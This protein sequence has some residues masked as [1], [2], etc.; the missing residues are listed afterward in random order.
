MS[1]ENEQPTM[2]IPARSV[3]SVPLGEQS[4]L[5]ESFSAIA[6]AL[7][8]SGD[9]ST[10]L[11]SI[12]EESLRLLHAISARVRMPDATGTQL[13]L[14]ALADDETSAIRLP[15]P[16]FASYLKTDSIAGRAYR[17]NE[18]YVARG[19][20]RRGVPEEEFALH[21]T[22]PLM[23]RNRTLGVLTIWRTTDEPF[24]DDDVAIVR[25]FGNAAA[26][27]IEQIR[28]LTEER[29]RT[30]RMETLTEVARIISAATDHDALYE[31]VYAQCVRLFGVEHFYIARARADGGLIPVLWYASARRERGLEGEPLPPSLGQSVVREN[32][33]I[34]TADAGAADAEHGLAAPR[35]EEWGDTSRTFHL[36][37][38]GVPIRE[39]DRATGVIATNGRVTPYT[40]EECAVL[41]AIADQVG[42][43]MRNIDLLEEQRA[44][45]RRME[46]VTEVSRA[47]SATTDL[48]TLYEAVHQEC[49]RLFSVESFYIAHVRELT[50]EMV[51]DLWYTRGTRLHDMEGVPLEGGLSPIVARTRAPLITDDYI[52]ECKRHGIPIYYPTDPNDVGDAWM[53]MPLIAGQTLLGV[54]VV[55]GK[56][57][58]YT[59][60]EQEVFTAIANQV[61]VAITNARLL[62]EKEARAARMAA[63]AEVSRAIS[64]VTDPDV[65]YDVVYRECSRL[66]PMA[67]SRICRIV[68]ETGEIIA[69][70]YF[71]N[72]ERARELEGQ[73]LRGGLSP[74]I[75]DTGEPLLT[76]DYP[77]E[78]VRRGMAHPDAPLPPEHSSWLGVPVIQGDEVYGIISLNTTDRPLTTEDR[79]MLLSVANQVGIA[80]ANARLIARE[81]ER[82]TRMATLTEIARAISATTDRETLYDAVYAQCARLFHVE[83]LRITRV[84]PETGE[85][86]PE[87]WY[88]DGVRRLDRESIPLRYGLSFIV[89]ETRQPFTTGD[90]Y[91]ERIARGIPVSKPLN[92]GSSFEAKG[93][94][95]VPMLAGDTLLGVI[96]IYGKASAYTADEEEAFVAIVNQVSVALQ[97]VEL[98]ERERSRIERLAVLN[99][100]SR[101]MSAMLDMDELLHVIQSETP[102]LFLSQSL[103]AAYWDDDRIWFHEE[104]RNEGIKTRPFAEIME[105]R[106]LTQHVA[107]N[108]ETLVVR[109]YESDMNRRGRT[110]R[111]FSYV[112]WPTAWVG[113]PLL[114][115]GRT[116]GLIAAF[117]KPKD[118]TEAGVGILE[119]IARQAAI[120][121]ENARL[122]ERERTRAERLAILN[123][124]SHTISAVLD[125]EPLLQAIARESTR[126]LDLRFPLIGYR[127]DNA[128]WITATGPT[129]IIGHYD[130]ES[131]IGPLASIVMRT[132]AP[133][134]VPDYETA[135][136]AHGLAPAALPGLPLPLGWIGVPMVVGADVVGV[137]AGF[138]AAEH[139][140]AEN[141]QL[142]S[143]MANQA[144]VAIENAH[145]YH[146]AQELGVVEERNRL[147]REIHDTIAQGLTA[148]TYQLELADTFLAMEPPKL[149]RAKEKLLRSLELTR[150]NLEEA[151]RSVMDLRAAHLQNATL[152]EAFE[153]LATT[154]TSDTDVVVSVA[155]AEDLSPLPSPV[156]AGLYRIGQEALANIAKHA[157]ATHVE[158]ALAVEASRVTLTIHD[159]G[160][161]FDPE[162]VATQRTARGTSG[163]FG[164]IGIR[165]RAQLMGGTSDISSDRGA[166]TRIVV[167]VPI[168]LVH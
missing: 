144:A 120:A 103:L 29:E 1:A 128:G 166:G 132:R 156:S 81:R 82:A 5:L 21:C 79:D 10:V 83:S 24:S 86:N 133:L 65:L 164:L 93:W 3:R 8:G 19:A 115:K 95:G 74:A 52:A 98:I 78:L 88:I 69:E 160:V 23:T 101:A 48:S 159:D 54:M 90:Y 154:F 141:A 58:P 68:P 99:D 162:V 27:A 140:T 168:K 26:L 148:T 161:G 135:C 110:L 85:Q 126:L 75:R 107:E 165:E 158:M 43:A 40:D 77:T 42:V 59:E 50:G 30:R 16:D 14:A 102:R 47:I 143:I 4:A 56:R 149:D 153:R 97:N 121:M 64:A 150:A 147:A 20:P 76:N 105:Q 31:A 25:I 151:R 80:M 146:D 13:L 116:I 124:I 9:L 51:P 72:G 49:G 96:A 100:L 167:R 17:T 22:V 60:A 127:A 37:W 70:S 138:I 137:L 125:L 57:A 118:V 34:T 33:P 152:V 94:L 87:F 112:E 84:N 163:G 155:A 63:L 91:A 92:D 122:L 89:A 35:G 32:M 109:D 6:E 136:R 12:A 53:G 139:A 123:D 106:A 145:L 142:L 129:A 134:F 44:R 28:L 11:Q 2:R 41:L 157:R 130:G 117:V 71:R 15:P 61:S 67:N 104:S 111:R 131:G 45:A 39:G 55:N 114:A 38:M 18:I 46:T 7:T 73:V 62:Q 119:L 108:G 113:V 66:L 36:P